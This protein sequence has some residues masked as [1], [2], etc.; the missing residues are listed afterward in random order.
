MQQYKS[1]SN[2]GNHLLAWLMNN[3]GPDIYKAWLTNTQYSF[4]V[5]FYEEYLYSYIQDIGGTLSFYKDYSPNREIKCT[6]L[7][8]V[9]GII[10]YY[11]DSEQDTLRHYFRG[12]SY[13][14][15]EKYLNREISEYLKQCPAIYQSRIQQY[16]RNFTPKNEIEQ[17]EYQK[18]MRE[19]G[20]NV[21]AGTNNMFNQQQPAINRFS[22]TDD[23]IIDYLTRNNIPVRKDENNYIWFDF[24][25]RHFVNWNVDTDEGFS[26]TTIK[27]PAVYSVT[28]ENILHC[29]KVANSLNRDK[30]GKFY[31]NRE[32]VVDIELTILLDST[33]ELD[34]LIPALIKLLVNFHEDF[35]KKVQQE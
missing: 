34:D 29:F 17:L 32:G 18:Y 10:G 2:V 33:P 27:L 15:L 22:S 5:D 20:N 3:I 30:W 11:E 7:K 13:E 35:N 24:N 25:G 26:F 21:N 8:V 6:E 31:V 9:D 4:P 12:T 19:L 23:L 14:D 16:G 1:L 28:K